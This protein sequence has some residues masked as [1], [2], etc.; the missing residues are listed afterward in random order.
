MVT[1]IPVPV[2][3]QQTRVVGGVANLVKENP[4]LLVKSGDGALWVQGGLVYDEGGRALAN[5]TIPGWFWEEYNKLTPEAKAAHGELRAPGDLPAAFI[6]PSAGFPSRDPAKIDNVV[7]T[8]TVTD[9]HELNK[10][11]I[12]ISPDHLKELIGGATEVHAEGGTIVVRGPQGPDPTAADTNE[13]KGPPLAGPDGQKTG[14]PED[15]DKTDT[16]TDDDAA[17]KADLMAL[18]KDELKELAETEG[19]EVG[20]SDTKEAIADKV[21]ASRR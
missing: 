11:Q 7:D 4:T 21:I 14:A 12:I 3:P 2:N 19:V 18:T 10:P 9:L 16:E 6:P 8:A 15:K 1:A 13:K 5:D 20:S 17:E